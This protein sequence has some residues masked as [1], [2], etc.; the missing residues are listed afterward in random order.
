MEFVLYLFNGL[1]VIGGLYVL[2]LLGM[3][4]LSWLDEVL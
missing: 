4:L 2:G 3:M 1:A